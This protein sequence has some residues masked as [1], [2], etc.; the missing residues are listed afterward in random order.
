[1]NFAYLLLGSNLEDRSAVLEQARKEIS[2]AIGRISRES[3]VYESEAWGFQTEHRFLNQVVMVETELKPLQLL[4]KMLNI[5][6]KLGRT[7][8]GEKGYTSRLIDIDILFY[9]DEVISEGRLRIPHPKIAE[10]M[11][12]LLPLAEINPSLIHPGLGKSVSDL[13]KDCKDKVSVYPYLPK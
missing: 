6:S 13:I 12:T 1:M 8:T 5:E 3:T 9:N 2:G 7:R 11:F 4:R 10:R